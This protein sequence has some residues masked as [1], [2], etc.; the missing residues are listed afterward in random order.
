MFHCVY[1]FVGQLGER[2]VL[3]NPDVRSPA[4]NNA[5]GDGRTSSQWAKLQ[6]S[7]PY[8]LHL[9][10][11]RGAAATLER[12]QGSEQFRRPLLSSGWQQLASITAASA[13]D[14]ANPISVLFVVM[15]VCVRA[16]T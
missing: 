14:S 7:S 13:G 12:Y 3:C 8:E 10:M 2:V 15:E 16:R 1:A 5:N 11:T 6:L 9:S 4:D